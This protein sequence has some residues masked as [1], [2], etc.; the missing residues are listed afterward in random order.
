MA[1]SVTKTI[2]LMNILF[3]VRGD[4]KAAAK[5][6]KVAKALRASQVAQNKITKQAVAGEKKAAR[7][8]SKKRF[9]SKEEQH[10]MVPW[11]GGWQCIRCCSVY[12][13]KGAMARA[14]RTPCREDAE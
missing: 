2:H 9:P 4:K 13:E 11:V 1:S 5:V 10:S 12:R 6:K 14:M 8:G 7:G 3:D